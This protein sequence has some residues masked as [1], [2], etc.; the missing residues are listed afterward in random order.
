MFT[1]INF[2]YLCLLY[3][4][5]CRTKQFAEGIYHWSQCALCSYNTRHYTMYL[6]TSVVNR[7]SRGQSHCLETLVVIKILRQ[8]CVH[9][10]I[11]MLVFWNWTSMKFYKTC[12]IQKPDFIDTCLST[13]SCT[14][15]HIYAVRT[16]F[17]DHLYYL[18]ESHGLTECW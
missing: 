7:Y 5:A 8:S 17:T 14:I 3:P 13:T 9:G 6:Y 16:P 2:I 1:N 4:N 10:L 15:R 12:H 18:T 11:S